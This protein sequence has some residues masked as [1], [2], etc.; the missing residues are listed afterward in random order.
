MP[1]VRSSYLMS[2]FGCSRSSRLIEGAPP[3]EHFAGLNRDLQWKPVVLVCHS[4]SSRCRI[5]VD[6]N[7]LGS[8]NW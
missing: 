1:V 5:I 7:A 2:V 8:T 4:C 6:R 3:S